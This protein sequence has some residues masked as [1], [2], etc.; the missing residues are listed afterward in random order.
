MPVH[1]D[2]QNQDRTLPMKIKYNFPL[3]N[4]M[5]TI[6]GHLLLLPK[7]WERVRVCRTGSSALS[8]H[9]QLLLLRNAEHVGVTLGDVSKK[10]TRIVK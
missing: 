9:Y 10:L 1:D 3:I 8:S 2:D 6:E 4:E 7:Y 5:K